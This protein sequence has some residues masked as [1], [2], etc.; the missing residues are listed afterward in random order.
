MCSDGLPGALGSDDLFD[1]LRQGRRAHT[2]PEDLADELIVLALERG[3][4]DNVTAL[5]VRQE[6]EVAMAERHGDTRSG[7][8]P[9]LRRSV[10]PF[11]LGAALGF[12]LR[13]LA[14]F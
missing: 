2:P 3:A 12:L 7:A 5:I 1:R 4:R 13:G 9:A 10:L 6:G 14:G 11:L 8:L